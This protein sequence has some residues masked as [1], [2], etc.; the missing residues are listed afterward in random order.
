MRRLT[1]SCGLLSGVLLIAVFTAAEESVHSIGKDGLK[2][3]AKLG[4][5]KTSQ[6]YHVKLVQGGT[7]VIDM[8]SPNPKTLD[9]FLRLLDATGKLLATD[10]DGGGGLNARL[11]FLAPATASYRL[12]ATSFDG[13]G[14]GAYTLESKRD[15]TREGDALEQRVENL[16]EKGRYP[17]AIEVARA[18][19]AFRQRVQGP[20][21]WRTIDARWTLRTL[22][23]V[24]ALPAHGGGAGASL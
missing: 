15:D 20:A 2:F 8:T 1:I 21:H 11:I 22:E 18:L 16:R 13:S 19:L 6:V 9:P 4:P 3:S 10:D 23:K 12:I 7:Y 24:S 14:V 5:D 17:Q